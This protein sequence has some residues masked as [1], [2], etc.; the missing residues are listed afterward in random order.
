MVAC[1]ISNNKEN[2]NIAHPRASLVIFFLIYLIDKKISIF[3]YESLISNDKEN[4]NVALPPQGHPR[5]KKQFFL[6]GGD[7]YGKSI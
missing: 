7:L 6:G 1:P 2:R 4:K 3:M 5:A